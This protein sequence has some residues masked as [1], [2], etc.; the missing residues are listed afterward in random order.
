MT[1]TIIY[2]EENNEVFNNLP[3]CADEECQTYINDGC[4]MNKCLRGQEDD[5]HL[6]QACSNLKSIFRVSNQ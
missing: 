6:A 2:S 4:M 3:V 1:S 5:E